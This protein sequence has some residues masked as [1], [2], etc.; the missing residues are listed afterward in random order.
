MCP[1]FPATHGEGGP[2]AAGS[3]RHRAGR[4]RAAVGV[5]S[6]GAHAPFRWPGGGPPQPDPLPRPRCGHRGGGARPGHPLGRGASTGATG[7]LALRGDTCLPERQREPRATQR[8]RETPARP[9]E[10][11]KQ[12]GDQ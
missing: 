5:M 8:F 9:Q 1:A 6:E 12:Q 10:L 4:A 7:S 3:V 11:P 2:L